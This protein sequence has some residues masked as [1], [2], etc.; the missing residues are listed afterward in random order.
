MACAVQCS[1]AM[2]S[3]RRPIDFD[4]ATN[5]HVYSAAQVAKASADE[6]RQRAAIIARNAAADGLTV[7]EYEDADRLFAPFA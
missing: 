6:A 1:T 7:A 3:T 4:H 2:K 5:R